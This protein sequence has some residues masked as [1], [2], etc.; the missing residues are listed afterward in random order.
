MKTL[1]LSIFSILLAVSL[2]ARENPFALYEEET[3]QMYDFNENL[4]TPEA[5]QEAEYIKKIQEKIKNANKSKELTPE[6]VTPPPP[7]IYTKQEVDSLIQKTKQ[8][9]IQN[10]K[11][12]VK[13]E[14]ANVKKEPEQIVYVKPRGDIEE[15]GTALTTKDILPFV[16]IEFNDDK[17]LIHSDYAMFKKFAI[18]EE[19][20]L[21]FD[22][23]AKVS[24]NSKKDS[25]NSKN[26]KVISIGN[27]AKGGF[28]RVVIELANKPSKYSADYKD[29]IVT[30]SSK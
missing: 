11:D 25:L 23:K 28:F 15:S 20:K 21:A 27:H 3:G 26:F 1:F 14:I 12:I 22:F 4:N 7:K 19:N 16:K 5:I 6:M 8:Q 10:T 2:N 18:N 24:F 13:K 29:N 30:I 17:I 9:T